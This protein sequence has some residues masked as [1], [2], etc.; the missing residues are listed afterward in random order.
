[1]PVTRA[2]LRAEL[3][4]LRGL[5]LRLGP[6]D[7]AL[8]FG[9][10]VGDAGIEAHCRRLGQAGLGAQV[11][12]AFE[13]GSL[14]AAVELWFSAG[15]P[16]RSCEVAIAVDA[17]WRGRGIGGV[18][19]RRAVLA[20]RNRWADRLRLSCLPENRRMQRLARRFT[21]ELR[22]RERSAEAEIR[23]PYPSW[24]S[25]WAEAVTDAAGLAA[26]L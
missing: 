14:V 6:D 25:L 1:M 24:P 8:R 22:I 18:L 20:A 10:A 3:P 16:P 13:D 12:G 15:P 23:L 4:A 11:I 2:V 26:S 17:R 19:L 5:L 9:A 7:R 21:H